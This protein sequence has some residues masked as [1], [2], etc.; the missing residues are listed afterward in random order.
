MNPS[1]E[2]LSNKTGACDCTATP[3]RNTLL[4]RHDRV[5]LKQV[6]CPLTLAWYHVPLPWPGTMSPYPG[7]V[8]CSLTLAWYHVPLP[9]PGTMSPY[10]GP[11]LILTPRAI[12]LFSGHNRFFH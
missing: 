11:T 10:P 4:S 6:S 7:L 12:P 3:Q 2:C 9:W 8:P 1:H 5:S